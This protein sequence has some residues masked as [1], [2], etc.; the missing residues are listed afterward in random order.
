M[1]L[2]IG[3]LGGL[4]M[5]GLLAF[6]GIIVYLLLFKLRASKNAKQPGAIGL[7]KCPICGGRMQAA[8]SDPYIVHCNTPKCPNYLANA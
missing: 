3:A 4:A 6:A 7:S 2:F 8:I 5:L 1:E